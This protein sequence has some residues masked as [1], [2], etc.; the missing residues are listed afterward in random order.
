MPVDLATAVV[1]ALP[2]PDEPTSFHCE[3]FDHPRRGAV[4][5]EIACRTGGGRINDCARLATG[6][7]LELWSCLGQAGVA[8]GA[9]PWVAARGPAGFVL[10]PSPGRVLASAPGACPLPGVVDYRLGV[11]P[12]EA[13]PRAEKATHAVAEVVFTADDHTDLAARHAEV[14][15]WLDR[16]LV[17]GVQGL[18]GRSPCPVEWGPMDLDLADRTYLVT[19]GSRG[20]GR[21]VVVALLDEGGR[22]SPPA[23]ATSTPWTRPGPGGLTPP[24]ACWPGPPTCA[25]RAAVAGLVADAVGEFGRLDGVVANAGAGAVGG[26]LDTPPAAWGRPVRRQGAGR[27]EPGRAG[28][29]PPRRLT[30]GGRGGGQRCHRPRPRARDGG[31]GR[32]AGGGRQPRPSSWPATWSPRGVRV[33]AVNLGAVATARQEAKHAASGST[34]PFDEWCDGEAARRGVPL[35]RLGRPDEVA[36]AVCFLLLPRASYVT[37]AALDVAGGLGALP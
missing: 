28:G 26:V 36:P 37:G 4:L 21:A 13:A 20:I 18:W 23:H 5:C 14:M 11:C 1:A 15:A 34:A 27:A 8:A 24:G 16:E 33:N 7:D 22:L 3:L 17:L 9:L 19:G 25:T 30:L 2:A 6:V 10:I 12:G 29:R 32:G 31:R 35:G